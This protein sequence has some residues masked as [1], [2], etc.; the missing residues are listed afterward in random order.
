MKPL[1]R[2]LTFFVLA[3]VAACASQLSGASTAK[4]CRTAPFVDIGANLTNVFAGGAAWGDY[5]SDGKLD[6]LVVGLDGDWSTGNPTANVYQNNGDGSFTHI[7]AGLPGV[8]GGGAVWGDYNNDGALDIL[9][10]GCTDVA[11]CAPSIVKIFRN[12]GDGTFSEDTTAD[13]NMVGRQWGGASWVD[14]DS[15]GNLDVVL[16]GGTDAG[17]STTVIFRNNGDGTFTEDSR[18]NLPGV[19]DTVA[20]GDYNNDGKPDV[21]LA[22]CPGAWEGNGCHSIARLYRNNGDGTFT[23]INAGLPDGFGVSGSWGDYNS[24]GRL[25]ILLTGQD[26][27]LNYFTRLYRNNG[28][29]TFKE[30][31][32]TGLPGLYSNGLSA[33]GDYNADGRPDLL[34]TGDTESGFLNPVTR[35]YRNNGDGTFTNIGADMIGLGGP[36]SLGWGDYNSDGKLD[37]LISGPTASG[38]PVTKIYRNKTGVSNSAPSAPRGL[39]SVVNGS[40]VTLSWNA[41][42]DA[43]TP[44]A[45]LTYNLRVGTTPGGAQIVSPMALPSGRGLLPQTGNAQGRTEAIRE[46]LPAGIYYW[47]V[48]AIDAG[49]AGSDFASE[50]TFVVPGPTISLSSTHY[51]VGEGDGHATVAITRSGR[52]SGTSSV[53]I[54]TANGTATAGSDYAAV[55]QTVTFSPGQTIK[56]VSISITDDA[57]VEGNE[58]VLVSLSSPSA[59]AA[60]ANPNS[61]TLTIED[62]DL[63]FTDIG[64]NLTGI[65]ANSN[66][67]VAWGDYNGDGKPDILL[68]GRDSNGNVRSIVYRNNGDGTFTDIGAVL[69]GVWGGGVDWG[70]YNGDG[71]LDIV[72]TGCTDGPC[73][74]PTV[75]KIYRN[76]GND[77][78]TEDKVADANLAGSAWGSA[79]WGDYNADGLLDLLVAGTLYRN[80]GDGTFTENTNAGLPDGSGA[81][82]AWGDYNNDG[83]PDIVASNCVAAGDQGACGRAY[84]KVYRNNGDGSFTEDTSA[85]LPDN[86]AFYGMPTWGDYNSDGRLDILL[87]GQ[88]YQGMSSPNFAKL[89]RNNGDGSFTEIT[90][91]GLTGNYGGTGAWGDYDSDG[92]PDILIP[93]CDRDTSSCQT[94]TVYRNNGDGSFTDIGADLTGFR[95]FTATWGDYNSDGKPDVLLTGLGNFGGSVT[96]IFRDEGIAPKTVEYTVEAFTPPID[97]PP[98]FNKAKAGKTI[99]VKWRLTDAN[100]V[101]VSDP[102]SF[103]SITSDSSACS[104]SDPIDT[105]ESY[106]NDSGLHYLGDGRWQF[107][108]KTPTS[109]TGECRVMR[110]NLASGQVGPIA[111]FRFK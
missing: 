78:F 56:T 55:D 107:N 64:A 1:P 110:L 73:S 35:V 38:A 28:D 10:A 33:W 69:T 16:H 104:A 98:T 93:S 46:Q 72:L 9:I 37:A 40:Q 85:G 44:T 80:N 7:N 53:T 109:Y 8:Y 42:S 13:A 31:K 19:S 58:T 5:D 52:A 63:G 32:N 18:A 34:L 100:G 51:S 102:A 71:K 60:L 74:A 88:K 41:A 17:H 47:S 50:R 77:S 108:W 59:G 6:V 49:Y 23:D 26:M 70:D 67:G 75:T 45:A 54:K 103:V 106:S 99:P 111:Y 22:G 94:A 87:T 27:S 92:R 101:P 65:F 29:G 86:D 79:V 90:N 96:K 105:I 43:T 66:N 61:A 81:S 4:A 95:I 20:W 48:Q 21:L 82:V 76:N 3:L 25:D 83:R 68:T 84:A 97:N 91:T 39:A 15:D 36:S 24:D 2:S 30:I 12:N 11:N 14:Y 89:Y 57:L 62:N